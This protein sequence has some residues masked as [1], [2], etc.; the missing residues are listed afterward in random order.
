MSSEIGLSSTP[1]RLLP[2]ATLLERRKETLAFELAKEL[3]T[4][5]VLTQVE[6][7]VY[8]QRPDLN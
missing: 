7:S 3:D 1:I 2:R 4:H 5:P 8:M 6:G